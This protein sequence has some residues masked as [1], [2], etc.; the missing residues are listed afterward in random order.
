MHLSS[1]CLTTYISVK[2]DHSINFCRSN[3]NYCAEMPGK[4]RKENLWTRIIHKP[5]YTFLYM[6][7][8]NSQYGWPRRARNIINNKI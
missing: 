7:V 3:E 8:H 1:V 5:D 2:K 4:R 6:K